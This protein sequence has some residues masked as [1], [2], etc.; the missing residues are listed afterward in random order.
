M[1]LAA[2]AA[3]A[4]RHQNDSEMEQT[5]ATAAANF[6]RHNN[7]DLKDVASKAAVS[8]DA[9]AFMSQLLKLKMQQEMAMNMSV[10]QNKIET[11]DN[12]PNSP[13]EVKGKNVEFRTLT[14]E[15]FNLREIIVDELDD[16]EEEEE[17]PIDLQR[18]SEE[19]DSVQS[20]TSPRSPSS[21]AGMSTS[22]AGK[23][24]KG[25]RLEQ[26]V[27]SMQR[28]SPS[29]PKES[30][31]ANNGA[32]SVNGCKKR[33]LYQPVQTKASEEDGNDDTAPPNEKKL[34]D[35]DVSTINFNYF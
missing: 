2:A 1:A 22:S 28:A 35:N 5:L 19:R 33:K 29:L 23:A 24:D 27:S 14:D 18:A 12:E 8:N 31:E 17:L 10:P 26:I 25:S 4:R 21:D 7:N 32:G 11:S 30:K 20:Q 15:R 13:E 9:T 34:K 16:I 3:V 6:A